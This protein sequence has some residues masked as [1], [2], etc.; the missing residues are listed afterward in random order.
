MKSYKQNKRYRI[1][2]RDK[3][4]CQIC[5]RPVDFGSF[6]L[7]HIVPRSSGGNNEDNNLQVTHKLCNQ[8]KNDY[9]GTFKIIR[10][11]HQALGAELL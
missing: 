7:D 3:C 5:G 2:N 9:N 11:P 6:T 1:F 10:V 4:I 8:F